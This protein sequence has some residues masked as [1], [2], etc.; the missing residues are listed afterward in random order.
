[1]PLSYALARRPEAPPAAWPI[2]E[3]CSPSLK[4]AQT[5]VHERLRGERA[6]LLAKHTYG[7]AST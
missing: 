4:P 2:L 5:C 7:A 6:F 1:M 3:V